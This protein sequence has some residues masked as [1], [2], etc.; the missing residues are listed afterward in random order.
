VGVC[1]RVKDQAMPRRRAKARIEVIADA[2]VSAK[3]IRAELLSLDLRRADGE[4]RER[5]KE[6]RELFDAAVPVLE[7]A[8][9]VEEPPA[10]GRR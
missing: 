5:L 3:Q 8:V 2:L 9:M 6:A 4:L 7:E 1:R 10:V